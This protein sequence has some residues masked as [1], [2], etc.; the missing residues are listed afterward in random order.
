MARKPATTSSAPV[1][2]GWHGWD[3]YAPFYD[4]ENAQT[5][6][7]RDV[8][9]WQRLA[10]RT[11]GPVLELG[12]GTGRVSLPL[13]RTAEVVVGVDRSGEMLA[14]AR[15]RL[16]RSRYGSRVQL[17]RGDIRALPFKDP[18]PFRLA[19]APYGILQSLLRDRDLEA[20]LRSVAAVLESGG[21]FGID[22]VPE[23]PDW[24]EYRRRVSLRG[25]R[26]RR[27]PRLTL[28]ESVR[29][30]RARRI[31]TFDQEFVEHGGAARS[32]RRFSIAFRTL[33][34]R[35]MRNR[36]ERSGFEIE[37]VLGDYRGR[38][39]DA[40]ADAWILLARRR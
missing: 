18:A 33:S 25:R 27:G 10:T 3:D 36:L 40:R 28:I 7:R 23:L 2:E 4:W 30:D 34:M 38:P 1:R 35:Q 24:R 13:A 6:Q 19:L 9:F 14:R 17:V 22:L 15:R 37:A 26:G 5:V 16:R 8:G 21:T 20:T 11:G 29:Q 39:W 31:T 32:R 12:C